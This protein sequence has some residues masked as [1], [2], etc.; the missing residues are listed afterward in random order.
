MNKR[1]W[2]TIALTLATI[3]VSLSLIVVQALKATAGEPPERLVAQVTSITQL[4]DIDKSAYYFNALQD[5]VERWGC[6][7]GYPDKTFRPNR[8]IVRAELI[9]L[10]RA[11]IDRTEEL[12][13]FAKPAEV[14]DLNQV[15]RRLDAISAAI[16]KVQR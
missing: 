1:I 14:G 11:C 12:T 9:S 5:L 7:V 16:K 15:R 3:L 13:V 2:K 10:V 6:I 8:P 4:P